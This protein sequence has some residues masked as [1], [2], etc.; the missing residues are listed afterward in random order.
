MFTAL[1]LP[2]QY[3]TKQFQ[4][5][6][7]RSLPIYPPLIFYFSLIHSFL[8]LFLSPS[9]SLFF[10]IFIF[11][12]KFMSG[13]VRQK[14]FIPE[15]NAG[16]SVFVVLLCHGHCSLEVTTAM[17]GQAQKQPGLAS[18]IA[19]TSALSELPDGPSGSSS[20]L[21]LS[22]VC[23]ASDSM[24]QALSQQTGPGLRSQT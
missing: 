15:E 21:S 8:F 14:Y 23:S 4:C 18:A 7:N 10:I 22:V 11:I 1:Y 2:L 20:L 13:Q 16:Q 9:L 17:P 5:S 6:E 12:F 3:H 24:F 19:T